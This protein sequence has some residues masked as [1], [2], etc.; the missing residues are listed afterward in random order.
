MTSTP[1]TRFVDPSDGAF[2]D[3]RAIETRPVLGA[4]PPELDR[5]FTRVAL[6]RRGERPAEAV[7]LRVLDREGRHA[8]PEVPLVLKWYHRLH[9]PDEEVTRQLKAL[10]EEPGATVE[11]LLESG[12]ADG[13][14]YHLYRS[15]G[16]EDL[17][18]YHAAHPDGMPPEKVRNVVEQ[19]HAA[20]TALH[21][22]GVVHR[23]I[24][25]DN[26]MV[27]AQRPD[28]ADLVL[29]D[30]GAAVYR[31]DEM[32]DPRHDWRGKPLYLAPEAGPL[33][34][35][36]SEEGD[37]W[38]VGMV[39]AQLALGKHPVDFRDDETV[40]G[41]IATHDPD[42]SGIRDRRTRNLCEGLLTRAP[43]DRWGARQVDAW[44]HDE[45]PDVAA[46]TDGRILGGEAERPTVRP[47]PFHGQEF[48]QTEVLAWHLDVNHR[49]A[50]QMLA[51]TE[52]RSK[53]VE[54]LEQFDTV[55][56]R[57][58]E[59][60]RRLA[61][62]RRELADPPSPE[63][64]VRLINWLGPSLDVAWHGAPLHVQG[65]RRLTAS[66]RQG[67]ASAGTLV[68]DLARHPQILAL[69][70]ERPQGEGLDEAA[71]RWQSLR[72]RWSPAV[73]EILRSGGV[74][75]VRGARAALRRTV[76]VDA[77]LLDLAREPDR[78]SAV[79]ADAMG[80]FRRALPMP[81]PWFDALLET[82]DDPLRLLAAHLLSAHARAEAGRLHEERVTE[83]AER[84]M[85]QDQDGLFTVL[86]R[87]DRL[88][89]LGWALLGATVVT[90]PWC[91]VTGLADVLGR[92][93]QEAVV[94]A[95]LEAL[96]GAAVVFAVELLTAVYIGPPFYHPRRSLAGL[97][98]RTAERPARL[99]RSRGIVSLLPAAALLTLAVFVGFYAI[100]FAPWAWPLAT[101]VGVA[102]WS[103]RRCHVWRRERRA[104]LDSR[105]ANR[106]AGAGA[107]RT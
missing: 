39:I 12:T 71:R 43:E 51:D 97:V 75:R 59:E 41:H 90:A 53:L 87:L 21:R 20:V 9:A 55:G 10:G 11:R 19:L 7:V 73:Q 83:E 57:S 5:R 27:P 13:H 48:T 72:G 56:G 63:G 66:A 94:L 30:F 50:G 1:P 101:A 81:V 32:T 16:E 70:A 8:S 40:L 102:G 28:S 99:A 2:T 26:I 98:I 67:D 104:H 29:I 35:T 107:P 4:V 86:R 64:V 106:R 17:G 34:Q 3:A 18:P 93:S 46:R 42:V 54:W 37:W 79:L 77:W 6:L 103:L 80:R 68:R 105:L 91:F 15:H 88:P 62:L 92:A 14:P 47:F 82:G 84:M 22:R 100:V 36:V 85:A 31:P 89:T 60:R 65:T 96:P 61:A 49:A 45:D 33:R 78:T 44:L 69:L 95:W 38:S 76:A 23:D 25:P 52:D 24:T 58:P 74:R